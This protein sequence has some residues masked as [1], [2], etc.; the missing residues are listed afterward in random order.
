MASIF[1]SAA[2]T[3]IR[4]RP[5]WGDAVTDADAIRDVKL[6]KEA[7]FNFIRGSHYPHSPAFVDACDRAGHSV[8]V[9]ERLLEHGAGTGRRATGMPAGIPLKAED[10]AEFEESSKRQ[11]GGDDPRSIGI[12]RRSSCGACAMSRSFPPMR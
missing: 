3:C 4:I 1:T 10:Q 2:R 11:L 5:G 7:G 9:R 12:T 6:M 8:L